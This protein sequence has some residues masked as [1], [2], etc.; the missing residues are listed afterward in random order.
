[1]TYSTFDL[2]GAINHAF[3]EFESESAYAFSENF[4]QMMYTNWGIKVYYKPKLH[5]DKYHWPNR[6]YYYWAVESICD[7]EKATMFK[8]KYA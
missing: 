2:D 3:R 6:N 7:L 4:I 8:L 1:M 5:G